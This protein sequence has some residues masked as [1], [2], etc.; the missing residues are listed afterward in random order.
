MSERPNGEWIWRVIVTF[1]FCS[2]AIG[3]IT[4]ST[5]N[6]GTGIHPDSVAYLRASE[7]I[8]NGDGPT[9]SDGKLISHWPPLYP[10][11]IASIATLLNMTPMQSSQWLAISLGCL[12]VVF[13]NLISNE[14]GISL[15]SV[16]CLNALLLSSQLLLQFSSFLSEGLFL[17]LMLALVYSYLIFRQSFHPREIMVMAIIAGLLTMTRYAGFAFIAA[18][19]LVITFS[20]KKLSQGMKSAISFGSAALL[21]PLGWMIYVKSESTDASIRTF[22]FHMVSTTHIWTLMDTV[23]SWIFPTEVDVV[24]IVGLCSIIGVVSILILT[25]ERNE[26]SQ[27]IHKDSL[28]LWLLPVSYTGFLVSSITLMD[29][30][31]PL[32]TRIL[33]PLIPLLLLLTWHVYSILST[34]QSFKLI[35]ASL[36]SVILAPNVKSCFAHHQFLHLN[37]SGYNGRLWQESETLSYAKQLSGCVV[38]TNGAD[39][40][41]YLLSEHSSTPSIQELPLMSDIHHRRINNQFNEQWESLQQSISTGDACVVY[42]N[43]LS[44]RV[45]YPAESQLRDFGEQLLIHDFSDGLIVSQGHP[46]GC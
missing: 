33:S 39:A 38:Y 19:C 10:I 11:A 41:S 22:D 12:L 1:V 29:Y 15:I 25:K 27:L 45:F 31:T 4:F 46:L 23:S 13:F 40:L 43:R 9:L 16:I 32:D 44:N 34:N 20:D 42:F 6:Y 17:V 3:L 37:G 30:S 36:I 26:Q 14:L 7:R 21:M 8:V 18:L 24:R 5:F 28:I 2:I 35:T